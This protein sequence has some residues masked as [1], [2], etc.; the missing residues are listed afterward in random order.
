MRRSPWA[1]IR[2]AA[3]TPRRRSRSCRR[4]SSPPPRRSAF[5]TGFRGTC[6]AATSSDDY[7][8][9]VISTIQATL[10]KQLDTVFHTLGIPL[11]KDV[12]FLQYQFLLY[13]I[14]LVLM[15][16][17]RPEGLFPSGRRRREL[18]A[19]EDAAGEA[20]VADHGEASGELV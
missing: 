9:I 12:T 13:G 6:S 17:L 8:G 10:L 7:R 15:M 5:P 20:L 11:L 14:A 16:V 2:S 1:S 3:T 4:W 19:T 18:H